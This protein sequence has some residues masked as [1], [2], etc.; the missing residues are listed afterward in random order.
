M[1]FLDDTAHFSEQVFY[2]HNQPSNTLVVV[3]LV[4]CRKDSLNITRSLW[5]MEFTFSVQMP[6]S[7]PQKHLI[8]KEKNPL[9]LGFINM[10]QFL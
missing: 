9:N 1:L 3:V 6:Y 2:E 8:Q 5:M 4:P 7:F 10:K